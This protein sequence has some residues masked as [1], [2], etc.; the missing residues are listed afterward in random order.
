MSRALTFPH[1]WLA[2]VPQLKINSLGMKLKLLFVRFPCFTFNNKFGLIIH[3]VPNRI[4]S[5]GIS[6][7]VGVQVELGK[8]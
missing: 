7:A 8:F 4:H 1:N 3:S 6:I 2:L 5:L